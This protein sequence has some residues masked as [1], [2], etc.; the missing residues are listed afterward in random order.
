MGGDSVKEYLNKIQNY[1]SS[2]GCLVV[3]FALNDKVIMFVASL[4]AFLTIVLMAVKYKIFSNYKK[5]EKVYDII[6]VIL[7]VSIFVISLIKSS[8][9]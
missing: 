8:K 9:V 6:A 4:L 7:F 5:R 3:L 1:V 2:F